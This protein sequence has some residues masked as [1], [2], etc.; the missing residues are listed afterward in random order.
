MS[1]LVGQTISH[2]RI[3]EQVGQGGIGVVYLAEDSEL[4]RKI[5]LK[6]LPPHYTPDAELNKRF[7]REA[8]AAAA[9]NHPNII[10]VHEIGEFEGRAYIAMEYVEGE[11]LREKV[12]SGRLT[13]SN[14]VGIA[15]QI[16]DGLDAAH[17]AGIIHRDIKPENIIVDNSGRVRILDFGLARMAGVSKLTKEGSTLGTVSYMS[18]EQFRGKPADHRADIW[19]VGVVL[20]EML[21]GELPFQG[22]HEQAV[23]CLVLNEKPAPMSKRRNDLPADLEQIVFNC[24]EK[25]PA[26]RYQKA[27]DLLTDLGRFREESEVGSKI[28]RST[29][30]KKKIAR[31][32]F[33]WTSVTAAIALVMM[34]GF[35]LLKPF[36]FKEAPVSEP[37]S[38]AVISFENMTGDST[39]NYLQNVIPNLFITSLEQS[40]YL[41]VAT[42]ARLRDL[43]K[44]TG[45]TEAEVEIITEDFGFELCRRAGINLIVTGSYTLAGDLF[46]TDAKVLNVATKELIKGANSKG[47]GVASIL[48]VQ[49]DEIS[50]EISKGLGS[51]AHKAG[52]IPTRIAEITTPSLEAYNYFIRGREEYGRRNPLN[53]VKFLKKAIE[54]D[55]TFATA[56]LYLGLSEILLSNTK[57][58]NIAYN[59]AKK[60]RVKASTKEQLFI[61]MSYAWVIEHDTDKALQILNQ[62]SNKYPNEKTV[63]QNLGYYYSYTTK[64]YD[65]AIPAYEKALELDPY[66]QLA[67]NRLAYIY[68]NQGKYEKALKYFQRLTIASPGDANP[69][70]SMADCYFAMGKI[71]EARTRY[72]EATD[73]DK[74]FIWTYIKRAYIHALNEDY[75]T[76]LEICDQAT[77]SAST[78]GFKALGYYWKGFYLFW[79]GQMDQA[80]RE[81]QNAEVLWGNVENTSGIAH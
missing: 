6:F 22:E 78:A 67:L 15:T 77:L 14:A 71:E 72:K 17:Q 54:F 52:T 59:K 31:P 39:Y 44:Q 73:V 8:K 21:T 47:T 56:Y 62:M 13:V 23:M 20:Y 76:T 49:I 53:A 79:L 61:D 27:S 10:T 41:R 12:S 25:T 65:K 64:N 29:A 16:C 34:L 37:R 48:D 50:G 26:S 33:K 32:R 68:V 36:I 5:A 45:K 63:F 46:V 38:I 35:M 55:S 80:L 69:F 9:L 2:Y 40:P 75:S 51:S 81:L 43:S 4:E 19:A 3:L 7:R 58:M 28:I 60:Y 11:S 18:P 24:L 30:R 42:L 74:D 66:Y 70:D 1:S 57:A